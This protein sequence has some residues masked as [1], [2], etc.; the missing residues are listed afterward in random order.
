[1]ATSRLAF[2]LAALDLFAGL[3]AAQE[4]TCCVFAGHG[5]VKAVAPGTGVL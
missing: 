5:V 3:A 4:A 2:A 1:M